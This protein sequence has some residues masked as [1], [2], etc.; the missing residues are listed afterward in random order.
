M[1]FLWYHEI[2]SKELKLNYPCLGSQRGK[3]KRLS[4]AVMVEMIIFDDK[5]RI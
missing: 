1:L 4:L 2:S 5:L 3:V